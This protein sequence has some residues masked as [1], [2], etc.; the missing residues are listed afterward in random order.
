MLVKYVGGS[1]VEMAK[2]RQKIALFLVSTIVTLV[3]LEI[4][5]RFYLANY[6]DQRQK[7][8]YLY[9]RDEI[10]GLKSKFRGLAYLN[11]GLRSDSQDINALGYRGPEI[12]LPK[13]PVTYRIAALGGS[14]T[15]GADLNSWTDAY[16]HQL[17]LALREESGDKRVEVINAG[18]PAYSSW[19][20]AVSFMFRVQDLEPDM[21]IIYQAINDINPRLSDPAFYDSQY[22][23]RGY[24]IDWDRPLPNCALCRYVLSKLGRRIE[25][26]YAL[27]EHLRAPAGY[28]HCELDVSVPEPRCANLEMSVRE[29]LA[30]NPPVYFERN[31]RNI[32]HMAKGSGIDVLLLTWAY[33]PYDFSLP[34]GAN[35]TVD[36]R[37]FAVAE[38]NEIT[39]R[40][41]E[42]FNTLFYDL[43]ESMPEDHKYYLDGVH[44]TL[45]GTA[46]VARQIA[47]YL[48]T[49]G[50]L[51]V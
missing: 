48:V 26:A 46:E 39:R 5:L 43:A 27:S 25:V 50:V 29:V 9:T 3:G 35:M 40:L 33:S 2:M 32:I 28:R 12:V 17:Q 10:S 14:T 16:P 23:G 15:F 8:Q 7:I 6:G 13:P 38:H 49:T 34:P 41:A 20:T 42:E 36:F 1:N 11:F 22:S 30:A 4:G 47:N 24:W 21:I 44:M 37:R 51:S 45:A 19:D 18:V 31:L